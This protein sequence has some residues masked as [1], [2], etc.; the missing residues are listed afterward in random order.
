M[1]IDPKTAYL[2]VQ[3]PLM[4]MV[5]KYVTSSDVKTKHNELITGLLN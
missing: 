2:M 1:L 3:P 4:E 5:K